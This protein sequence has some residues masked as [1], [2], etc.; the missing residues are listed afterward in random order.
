[1]GLSRGLL[2]RG[3]LCTVND[4]GYVR[5]GFDFRK[6][7]FSIT[8]KPLDRDVA[9]LFFF[10]SSSHLLSSHYSC[11]PP[12]S[13]NSDSG[14]HSGALLPPPRYSTCLRFC[15]K[16]NS[17]FIF[18]EKNSAFSSLADSRRIVPAQGA[19]RSQQLI[20]FF[21]CAGL[22]RGMHRRHGM[23]VYAAPIRTIG[24]L[25]LINVPS[26]TRARP[27]TRRSRWRYSPS[28]VYSV[29]S[30]ATDCSPTTLGSSSSQEAFQGKNKNGQKM[31]PLS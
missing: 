28:I 16:N 9:T 25:F 8:Q 14:S 21:S 7:F 20:P 10:F 22:F 2:N 19:R 26:C 24:R 29:K 30:Q 13:T 27:K 4:E 11:A 31:S 1:M 5:W 17:F 18:V 6:F 3:T 15:R 23:V 12:P